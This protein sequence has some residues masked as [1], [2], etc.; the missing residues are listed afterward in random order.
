MASDDAAAAAQLLYGFNRE[1]DDPTPPP[2]VL[3][4]SLAERRESLSTTSTTRKVPFPP[5]ATATGI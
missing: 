3:A 1:Y 2:D 5:Y 4:V